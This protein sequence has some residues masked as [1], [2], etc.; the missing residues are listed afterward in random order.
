MI[1]IMPESKGNILIVRAEG[2]LTDN[3]YKNVFIPK[4]KEIIKKYGSIRLLLDMGDEFSGWEGSALWDD[5]HFG[6]EN[7]DS[8]QKMGVIANPKWVSIGMKLLPFVINGEIINFTTK[9]REKA[10]KWVKE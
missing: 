9:E 4:M 2:K 3:D 6:I 5:L 10:M 1:K 8:F 7:K